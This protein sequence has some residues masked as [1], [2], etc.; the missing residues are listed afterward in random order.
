MCHRIA[1]RLG[2]GGTPIE[3]AINEGMMPEEPY[4]DYGPRP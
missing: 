4:W 1:G 3:V 2:I